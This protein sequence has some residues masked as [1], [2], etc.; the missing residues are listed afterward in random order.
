M[1]DAFFYPTTVQG[2]NATKAA[3]QAYANYML[4]K[5]HLLFAIHFKFK[6][7]IVVKYYTFA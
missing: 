1:K 3:I 4:L 7:V 5:Q 2:K 6:K